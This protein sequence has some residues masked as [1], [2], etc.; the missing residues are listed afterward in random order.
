MRLWGASLSEGGV[1]Q[2]TRQALTVPDSISLVPQR[3]GG[4]DGAGDAQRRPENADAQ[5]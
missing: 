3:K 5:E 2:H 4:K 1:A